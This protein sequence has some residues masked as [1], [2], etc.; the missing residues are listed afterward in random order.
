MDNKEL[1]KYIFDQEKKGHTEKQITTYLIKQG[2]KKKE[3]DLALEHHKDDKVI[4]Y[5]LTLVFSTIISSGIIGMSFTILDLGIYSSILWIIAFGTTTALLVK[6]STEKERLWIFASTFLASTISL[7]VFTLTTTASYLNTA[8]E[9]LSS[10]LE[11][12]VGGLALQLNTSP[13]MDVNPITSTVI[14]YIFF[15]SPFL[16]IFLMKKERDLKQLLKIP[17]D[18]IILVI[19]IIITH[20]ILALLF[21]QIITTTAI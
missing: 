8:L 17:I 2:H 21:N 18:I 6:L 3:I 4:L 14:T 11:Q 13:F 9:Q 1:R 15:I 20:L 16:I 5:S 19:L 12:V 10:R 7:I